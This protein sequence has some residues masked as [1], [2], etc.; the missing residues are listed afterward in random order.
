MPSDQE[1]ID[2]IAHRKLDSLKALYR[3]LPNEMAKKAN[4]SLDGT[5]G[6]TLLL[7]AAEHG[8][9]DICKFLVDKKADV[10]TSNNEGETP[11]ILATKEHQTS[12]AAFLVK[13]IEP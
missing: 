9:A 1:L 5:Q 2:I 13:P 8:C 3:M 7:V 12:T 11:L 4:E 6:L 10:N